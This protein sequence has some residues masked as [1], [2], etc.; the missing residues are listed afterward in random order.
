MIAVLGGI[1]ALIITFLCGLLLPESWFMFTFFVLFFIIILYYAFIFK[2]IVKAIS[3][4]EPFFKS[5]KEGVKQAN[6]DIKMAIELAPFIGRYF[7]K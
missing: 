7:N 2:N 5:I 6:Q 4:N 1:L 3:N